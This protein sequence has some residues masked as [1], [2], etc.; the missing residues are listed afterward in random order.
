V[1]VYIKN[2]DVRRNKVG[3]TDCE[4]ESSDHK[5]NLQELESKKSQSS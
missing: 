1:I 4:G 3:D 5:T 2:R